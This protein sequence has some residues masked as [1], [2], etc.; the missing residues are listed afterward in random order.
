MTTNHDFEA[1]LAA[2]KPP[3]EAAIRRVRAIILAADGRMTEYV[4]YRTLTFAYR[5]DLAAFVQLRA[6]TATL[7][8]NRGARIEGDYPH[9][10]GDG[11]S[12]RFMRFVDVAEVEARAA[13]LAA[14]VVAWGELVEQSE[15]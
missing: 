8:F 14:I 12:A 1:W 5:G 7:M 15:S 2:T 3:A 4:K 10:E 9:L 6:K 11:P 13:E